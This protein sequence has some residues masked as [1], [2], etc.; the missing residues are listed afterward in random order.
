MTTEGEIIETQ[1]TNDTDISTETL[2]R[3]GEVISRIESSKQQTALAQIEAT[4]KDN[5]RQFEYA[6]FQSEISKDKW[7]KSFLVG[8]VAAVALGGT[9]LYLLVKGDTTLGLG[10]LSNTFTGVFA[11]LAGV[12]ASK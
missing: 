4:D 9:G 5:E 3:V 11:Y 2:E 7:N 12:G 8:V 10:L 6:K 1:Q